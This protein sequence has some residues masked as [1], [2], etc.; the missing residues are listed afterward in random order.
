MSLSEVSSSTVALLSLLISSSSL[1]ISDSSSILDADLYAEAM[2][3]VARKVERLQSH[4]EVGSE[5]FSLLR[6]VI[7]G[8]KILARV[9]LH[10]HAILTTTPRP[11]HHSLWRGTR[12]H[13]DQGK[14]SRGRRINAAW[15]LRALY[16][17]ERR[18][19]AS[20]P[21][22]TFSSWATLTSTWQS[23]QKAFHLE[24]L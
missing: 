24:L 11:H 12:W 14:P 16:S 20:I 19:Q 10:K 1:S 2:I 13:Q 5:L 6:K 7:D 17:V 23:L 3:R 21:F 8:R 15:P 9:A 4:A 18:H 22:S